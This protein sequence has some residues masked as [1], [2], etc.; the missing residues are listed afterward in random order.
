MKCLI[1]YDSIEQNCLKIKRVF[2]LLL[3]IK[4]SLLCNNPLLV[5]FFLFFCFFVFDFTRGLFYT[6]PENFAEEAN[7][8]TVKP[9]YS[10]YHRDLK[11]VSITERSPLHS[12][13]S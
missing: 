9:L 5:V 6:K 12:G 7:L 11:I 3:F 4:V 10:G 2:Y 1:L 8:N 13:S